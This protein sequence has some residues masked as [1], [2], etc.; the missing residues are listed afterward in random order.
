[1]KAKSFILSLLL[2]ISAFLYGCNAEKNHEQT[3]K[4]KDVLTIYTTVYPLED[5][6]KK[7]GGDYVNVQSIYPPGVEAHTFEPTT[8]TMKQLADADAF[9]YIGQGMESFADKIKET[10][11]N[12]QVHFLAATEGIELLDSA[13][14]EHAHEHE[15]EQEHEH[16]GDKD[17][18]V[19]LD[20]ARS[21][22]IAEHIRDLLIELKP[23][24][25]ETFTKNFEALKA[26]LEHLDQ[27]F[28]TVV[29][30]APKKE[31]LVAH[32]AYGY[33]EDR[34]GIKQLS[35]SGLSPTNEPSQKELAE[36][37]KIAKQHHIKYVIFEQNTTSKITEIVKNEIGADSLRLHNLESL[38]S[39]DKKANKDYFTL[40]EENIRVLQK[41]LQ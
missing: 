26:K 40:M 27:Q 12:E 38:T 22:A 15:H 7:I 41:A 3:E 32:A 17:P 37:V 19:W 31:I 28:Q 33:W 11:K 2:V 4:A 35:V 39:E 8:K 29:K 9:I 18:H 25:K 36:I 10:L 20:P 13:H 14:E 24:K 21:I 34:Y 6:T 16:H 1:M 23:E 30:S 5:F